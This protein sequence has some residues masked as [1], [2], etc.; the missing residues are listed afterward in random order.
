MFEH[1]AT[2][3]GKT[4]CL[5]W[6]ALLP[7]DKLVPLVECLFA[8]L[9]LT[10][11]PDQAMTSGCDAVEGVSSETVQQKEKGWWQ[12]QKEKSLSWL[13]TRCPAG[14]LPTASAVFQRQLWADNNIP[15]GRLIALPGHGLYYA[16]LMDN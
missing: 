13:L 14:V 7:L 3:E 15:A 12:T 11:T 2:F 4:N 8:L 10:W 6:L 1:E 5:P 9:W 16:C